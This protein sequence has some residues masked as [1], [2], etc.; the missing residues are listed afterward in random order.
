MT[1]SQKDKYLTYGEMNLI[2]NLRELWLELAMWRRAYLISYAA[3]FGDLDLVGQRLYDSSKN[4]GDIL[5]VFFGVYASG[6]IQTLLNEQIAISLEILNAESQKDPPTVDEATARL[7][8]NADQ[9][10]AYLAQINPYWSEEEWKRLLYEYYENL[11]LQMVL[12]F[13]GRYD[14]AIKLFEG[15]EDQTLNIADYMAKGI[16]YYFTK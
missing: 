10:A 3:N 9:L 16:I 4:L 2:N 6:R 12:V 8:Q 14:E 15:L 13:A 1:N 11:I 7:Y 5:K